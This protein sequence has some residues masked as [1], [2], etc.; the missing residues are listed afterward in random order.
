MPKYPF[1]P[2]PYS[3][4]GAQPHPQFAPEVCFD[5]FS[6]ITPC[7]ASCH[8]SSWNVKVT[9]LEWLWPLTPA[10]A[11]VPIH[12]FIREPCSLPSGSSVQLVI[13]GLLTCAVIFVSSCWQLSSGS[14]KLGLTCI[15]I[16]RAQY[17]FCYILGAPET[18]GL[19]DECPTCSVCTTY[20][21]NNNPFPLC[22]IVH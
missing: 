4:Y 18:C 3:C 2:P 8:L 22:S 1:L 10:Q 11:G 13:L 21:E 20:L 16:S 14:G 12:Y 5:P 19:T 15:D 7:L 17:G 9:A 6:P